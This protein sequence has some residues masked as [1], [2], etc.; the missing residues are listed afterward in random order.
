MLQVNN[1]YTQ[2]A[3][4][5]HATVTDK[6]K[7]MQAEPRPRDRNSRGSRDKSR[8]SR[9]HHCIIIILI[10]A[11]LSVYARC[12]TDTRRGS[13]TEVIQYFGTC[14]GGAKCRCGRLKS[15]IFEQYLAISKKQCN[16][17]N[18]CVS[19]KCPPFCF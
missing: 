12:L 4:N 6:D 2:N 5:K 19:Q 11:R 7:V 16:T 9:H 10:Q 1:K 14:N 15:A 18:I 3:Q 8:V 17:W 13:S